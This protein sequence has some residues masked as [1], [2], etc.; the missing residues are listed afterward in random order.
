MSQFGMQT[1]G[2]RIKRGASPDVYTA[3][4]AVA[5]MFLLAASVV[6]FFVAGPK[7][8]KGGNAFGLQEVG[9]IE[10]KGPSNGSGPR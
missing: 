7:V 9:K 2:G 8:G 10:L 4:A 6:M 1:A 3:M 5:V